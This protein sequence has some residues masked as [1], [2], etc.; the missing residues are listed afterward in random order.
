MKAVAKDFLLYD[1]ETGLYYLRS[2]YYNPMWGRFVN[3]DSVGYIIGKVK[4]SNL[5]AY[6]DNNCILNF[7][8]LYNSDN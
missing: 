2:R 7:D 8:R 1:E 3:A 4:F 5:Y 6:C